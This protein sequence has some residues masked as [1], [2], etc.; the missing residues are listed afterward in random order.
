MTDEQEQIDK[1]L[2]GLVQNDADA[3][4]EIWKHFADKISRQA[5]KRLSGVQRRD[6]DE[7]DIT[8]RVLNSLF[9]RLADGRD[10]DFC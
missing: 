9:L 5:K 1:W 8:V 3:Q 10:R 7:E 4:V 6:S 2:E